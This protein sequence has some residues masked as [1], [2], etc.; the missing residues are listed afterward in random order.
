MSYRAN[1]LCTDK[2]LL[3]YEGSILTTFNKV[4]W[5]EKRAK[6]LSDW[7]WPLLRQNDFPIERFRTRY[8]RDNR[9]VRVSEEVL[10]DRVPFRQ[11]VRVPEPS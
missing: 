1:D 4:E 10:C 5:A 11:T 8:R 6:A 9:R 2:D 3:S 7:L